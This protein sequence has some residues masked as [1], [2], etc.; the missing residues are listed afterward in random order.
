M[1]AC[2]ERSA[3]ISGIRS[4]QLRILQGQAGQ[5]P[6][7]WDVWLTEQIERVY[8]VDFADVQSLDNGYSVEDAEAVALVESD[9]RYLNGHF[10][11]PR[12]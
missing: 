10:V 4:V 11:F 8:E 3:R 7:Y 5:Q 9:T 12:P 1:P 6:A 2:P